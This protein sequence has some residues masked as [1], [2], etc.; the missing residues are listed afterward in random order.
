M[1]K[2]GIAFGSLLVGFFG[3]IAAGSAFVIWRGSAFLAVEQPTSVSGAL[4][5]SRDLSSAFEPEWR[6]FRLRN[7]NYGEQFREANRGK[8]WTSSRHEAQRAMVLRYYLKI[9]GYT[10]LA[11][12]AI[13]ALADEAGYPL[14][15]LIAAFYRRLM[16]SD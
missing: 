10:A 16:N 2:P 5:F 15:E 13:F 8:I 14:G 9:L 1:D 11:I 3:L 7:A 4:W 6:R 12:L